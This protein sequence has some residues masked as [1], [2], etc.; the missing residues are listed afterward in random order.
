M[1]VATKLHVGMSLAPTWLSGEAWRRADSG[2][3]GVFSSDYFVD[4]AQR[5]EAAHVDFVFRPDTLFLR[6]E[7]LEAGGGFASMDPTMLL[8]AI[9]R[10]TS[11]VGL[12]STVSTTFLPPYVVAR[13][14]QSLNWLSSGRAGWNIVTALDGHENFGLREMPSPQERYER[15]AEFTQVVQQLWASFPN[16]AL[17]L[18][19]ESGRFA[20]SS[21]VHPVA[22]E[23]RHFSVK[24]P[25][26]L[27]AHASRIPLVQAGASPEGRDFASSVADAVF[28]ST[29]DM[30][31]AIELRA[32]LRRRAEGHGRNPDGVKLMP[33]LSL[34]LADSGKEALEL[35][36]ETHARANRGRAFASIRDMTGLDL[37]DWP[38]QRIV[39]ASDL[40]PPET[41]RSR[42]HANLLRRLIERETLSVA[43]LLRR[44]EVMGSGHWQIIGTVDDALETIREWAAAGAIDGFVAVP[45][46][47]VASMRLVLERL[48]PKL[49]DAG[50]FRTAYSGCT[51]AEHLAE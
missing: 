35:F 33:G 51:F 18:D 19:R 46:G 30:Q 29:P 48:L 28:A 10:E 43:D 21:L 13:Q 32:D 17:K 39:S 36:A 3:N 9:A 49:A 14:I 1:S 40:P 47:S 38:L 37:S 23:G 31:A 22:H 20:D 4:L 11:H 12:L 8:A 27:P 24:G 42:T 16:E 50:L 26:N 15:A 41:P 7:G 5:A 6:T 25:L 44:P 2:I 34:Y 45:G